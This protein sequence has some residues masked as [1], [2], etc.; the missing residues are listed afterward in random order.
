LFGLSEGASL[1]ILGRGTPFETIATS[2]PATGPLIAA[3]IRS[4]TWRR[5]PDDIRQ[6][7]GA[8]AASEFARNADQQTRIAGLVVPAL[9]GTNR[10]SQRRMHPAAETRLADAAHA[11]LDAMASGDELAN[12]LMNAV[13]AA[14]RWQTMPPLNGVATS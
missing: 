6:I 13:F 12:R 10:H 14:A 8:V 7:S 3:F 4:S 11:T 2:V 1:Q 9:R 5:L